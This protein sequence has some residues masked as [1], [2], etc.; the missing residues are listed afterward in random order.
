MQKGDADYSS[1]TDLTVGGVL[2]AQDVELS[3]LRAVDRPLQWMN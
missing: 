3:K 1:R 2:T